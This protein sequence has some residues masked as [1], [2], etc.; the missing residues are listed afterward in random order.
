MAK[1]VKLK[2]LPKSRK[3]RLKTLKLLKNNHQVLK[4]LMS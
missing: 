3:S 1:N 2:K 4:K